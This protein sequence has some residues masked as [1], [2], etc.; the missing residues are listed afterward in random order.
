MQLKETQELLSWV[1][2]GVLTLR[3]AK[4]N[5]GKITASDA[6]AALPWL[7]Q[8]GEAL[9]G[10]N[11]V[12]DEIKASSPDDRRLLL[13]PVA[14]LIQDFTPDD[15]DDTIDDALEILARFDAIAVRHLSKGD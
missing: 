12:V 15:V 11:D 10:I 14:H 2:K 4:A 8:T 1:V 3:E 5:D 6:P 7:L 13:E 9:G